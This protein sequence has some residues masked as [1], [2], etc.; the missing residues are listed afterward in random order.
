MSSL[1]AHTQTV[2]VKK[3]SSRIKGENVEGYATDLDGKAQDVTT[4]FVKYLRSLGKVKQNDGIYVLTESSISASKNPIYCTTKD[5]D[6]KGTAWMG[7]VASE[8]GDEASKINSAIEKVMY[9]Y[10][11]KFYRDKI[12]LQIDESNRAVAAVEK[13]QQRYLMENKN[14]NA[15]LENNKREKIQL[16]KNLVDNKTEYDLL[17]KKIAKNKH[18]QDSIAIANVQIKKVMEA[19]KE[20]QSK[21]K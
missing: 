18:D 21:V 17:L 3:E 10:G 15:K 6:T 12:Q 2:K 11:V 4:S 13:Q 19:Q 1:L 16:E 7:I 9:E 8:W 20:K 5:H 14:L